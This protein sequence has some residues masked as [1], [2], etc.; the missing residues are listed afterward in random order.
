MSLRVVLIFALKAILMYFKCSAA[1]LLASACVPPFLANCDFL[2]FLLY[3][4]AF[5][6]SFLAG[7]Q[8]TLLCL[9]V[10]HIVIFISG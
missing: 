2:S 10:C 1:L 8:C 5:S 7:E 4:S 9:N 6:F 3:P